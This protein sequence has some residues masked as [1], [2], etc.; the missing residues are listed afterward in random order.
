MCPRTKG[1]LQASDGTGRRFRCKRVGKGLR[2][3]CRFYAFRSHARDGERKRSWGGD[4][5]G[6][7]AQ[8]LFQ[9][10]PQSLTR[11]VSWW[12]WTGAGPT[13][14]PGWVTWLR[15]SLA[16]ARSTN[17]GGGS[18]GLGTGWAVAGPFKSSPF[19]L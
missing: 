9:E 15:W 5:G 16:S 11:P 8:T 3:G 13:P 14:G 19:G 4:G 2:F 17:P 7:Q 12:P 1:K 18:S 10:M 6:Q